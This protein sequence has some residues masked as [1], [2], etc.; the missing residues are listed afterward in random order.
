V[1]VVSTGITQETEIARLT[2]ELAESLQ[3]QT[4]TSEVLRVI[5]S[6][7]ADLEPVFRV[8]LTNATRACEAKFGII[9]LREGTAFRCA[10]VHNVPP[11]FA[12]ERRREPLIVPPIES[13]LGRILRTRQ[14]THVSDVRT[15]GGYAACGGNRPGPHSVSRVPL[16]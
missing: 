7:P 4:A 1:V 16:L 5:S 6:S 13:P 15:E 8:M 2:R 11:A 14:V 10:A 12:E 3:Q 9:W